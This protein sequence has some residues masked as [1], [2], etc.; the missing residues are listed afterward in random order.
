[1]EDI[2]ESR[3][4]K[5]GRILRLFLPA[6]LP[7]LFCAVFVVAVSRASDDTI[8][9]EQ[10]TLSKALENGAVYTYALTGSYPESLSQLLSDYNITYDPDK[11]IVEY[12]PSGSNLFPMIS[13]LPR[14]GGKGGGS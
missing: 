7:L 11:F 9:K 4:K 12:V 6:L 8:A 10:A 5:A 2:F 1:M 3:S 13:V 14:S